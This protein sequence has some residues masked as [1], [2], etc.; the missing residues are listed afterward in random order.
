MI[1]LRILFLRLNT[2]LKSK[3]FEIGRSLHHEK[4]EIKL[5]K[6]I[7]SNFKKKFL[8][9]KTLLVYKSKKFNTLRVKKFIYIF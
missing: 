4:N 8:F 1:I 5:S 2:L 9:P 6:L 7:L 3:G